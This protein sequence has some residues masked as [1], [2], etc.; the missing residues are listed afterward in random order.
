MNTRQRNLISDFAPGVLC[1]H[2][3]EGLAGKGLIQHWAGE[4]D[5]SSFDLR[6]KPGTC[7]KL[8]RGVVKPAPDAKFSE[9]LNDPKIATPR[10]FGKGAKIVIRPEQSFVFA[11]EEE[12]IIEPPI[13]GYATGRSSIG[14]L[15]VLVRLIGDGQPHYDQIDPPF[16]GAL[17]V[18][19]SPITFAIAVSA[20]DAVCQLRL[21]KGHPS[22]SRL[23]EADL[24]G[25]C[26]PILRQENSEELRVSTKTADVPNGREA[27]ALVAR[28]DARSKPPIPLGADK[29]SIRPE[30]YWQLVPEEDGV[31]RIERDRFYIMRSVERFRL[32]SNVA[33]YAKAMN[34]T[35]G[36]MRIHYAGFVH[37]NFGAASKSGTPL[38]FE[39]RGHNIDVL[40]RHKEILAQLQYFRMSEPAG[41]GDPTYDKQELKLAKFFGP[42]K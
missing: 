41:A 24:K 18:E 22:Q 33:V 6:I 35:L 15:D 37:P 34:E 32:P 30:E 17:Y 21:F 29:D 28:G 16:R 42:W 9:V 36:E 1:D 31:L 12:L 25:Y 7:W 10:K 13:C 11:I 38:I 3:I 5:P 20:Y 39:V 19:I 4:P 23:H 14:R 26:E 40:L 27:A 2:Q 8:R